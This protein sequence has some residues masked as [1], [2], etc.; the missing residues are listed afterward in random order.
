MTRRFPRAALA[1]VAVALIL[2]GCGSRDGE[3]AGIVGTTV[4]STLSDIRVI[5]PGMV[6]VDF[7]VQNT[8]DA[9]RTVQCD[10][11]VIDPDGTAQ[12]DATA[13]I[14]AVAAGSE[15]PATVQVEVTAEGAEFVTE[16]ELDCRAT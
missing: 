11:S 13:T 12:G 10:V 1:L 4:P 8:T 7:V 6:A 3:P 15:Q 9:S 16:A 14:P 5:N 2:A